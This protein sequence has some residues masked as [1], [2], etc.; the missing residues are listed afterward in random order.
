[1]SEL[2][3]KQ[4]IPC[5]G[6]VPPLKEAEIKTLLPQLSKGWKVI[7]NYYLEKEYTFKDFKEALS[8]TN[9]V[10]EVAEK[11][12]HHPD[13][14]LS[15]GKVKISIWTHKI[16]GLTENDFILAAKIDEIKK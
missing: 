11:E 16:D 15:W 13:I 10:G 4:C 1:M 6:G 12:N 7:K 5:K 3:K 8:F 9:Q 2:A 14:Y